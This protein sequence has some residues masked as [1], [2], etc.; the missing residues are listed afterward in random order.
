MIAAVVLTV[1]FGV[2]LLTQPGARPFVVTALAASF[3]S[4]VISVTMNGTAAVAPDLPAQQT[5]NRYTILP[6]FLITSALIVGV[7]YA[8]RRRAHSR[9]RAGTDLKP[10]MAVTALV[11]FLAA[12]WAVD[13]RYAG[14]RSWTSTNWA[15]IAAKWERDCAHSRTGEIV[16][17][18]QLTD[19]TLPCR[20][21]T[22]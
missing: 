16:E 7:D 12:T 13:F 22:P 17:R 18:L 11:V 8:L 9:R 4:A 10:A 2:I 6:V 14:L 3:I 1:S 15:P 5:G 21:I 20:N 19:Q